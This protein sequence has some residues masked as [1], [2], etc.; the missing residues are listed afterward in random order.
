MWQ[1]EQSHPGLVEHGDRLVVPGL[2]RVAL[3]VVIAVLARAAVRV[4]E[5][6]VLSHAQR[7]G[8]TALA[9][10]VIDGNLSPEQEQY[11]Y[12][13]WKKVVKFLAP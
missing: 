5:A 9:L 6:V 3:N 11:A 1:D 7:L 12:R 4:E 10:H 8:L 2:A 13:S